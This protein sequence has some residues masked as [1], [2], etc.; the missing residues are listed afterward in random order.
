MQ[1]NKKRSNKFLPV[2]TEEH[3]EACK[4]TPSW[5]ESFSRP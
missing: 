3:I 4:S 5:L 2:E 1:K